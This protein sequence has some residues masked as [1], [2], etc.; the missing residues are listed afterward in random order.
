MDFTLFGGDERMLHA[1]LHLREG[2]HGVSLTGFER[3]PEALNLT[4]TDEETALS[5]PRLVLGQPLT[6]DGETLFSPYAQAPVP[7]RRIR[8]AL[9]GGAAVFTPDAAPF[10]GVPGVFCYGTDEDYLKENARLTALGALSTLLR[11]LPVPVWDAKIAVLGFGRISKALTE[12]LLR[13]GTKTTVF[14]RRE[15]A[16]R[17]A[18]SLGAGSLPFEAF[19]EASAAFD[20]VVNTVPARALSPEE[21][22]PLRRDCLL[23]ELAGAPGG[24]PEDARLLRLPGIPGRFFPKS[25]G[26]A[27]ARAVLRLAKGGESL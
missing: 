25:A 18:L 12:M 21:L 15:K 27:L 16:R 24:F 4:F 19:G 8:A 3:F 17:E 26:T 23:L 2:G 10:S 5:A 14:A 11:R 1:A 22:K 7:L 6:R 9:E 20:A 13:Y